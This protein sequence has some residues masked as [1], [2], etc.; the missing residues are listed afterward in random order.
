METR[1]YSTLMNKQ[2]NYFPEKCGVIFSRIIPEFHKNKSKHSI[3]KTNFKNPYSSSYF[4]IFRKP[5]KVLTLEYATARSEY[6][7][8]EFITPLEFRS[9]FDIKETVDVISSLLKGL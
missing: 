8:L 5:L 4:F 7:G 3:L 6:P 2:R 9:V 1:I